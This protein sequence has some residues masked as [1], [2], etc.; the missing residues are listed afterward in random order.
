MPR[1]VCVSVAGA[2]P[3]NTNIPQ[4]VLDVYAKAY[5]ENWVQFRGLA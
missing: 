5:A 1:L 4:P 2:Q 3:D